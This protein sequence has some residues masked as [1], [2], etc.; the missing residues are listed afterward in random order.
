MVLSLLLAEPS[1]ALSQNGRPLP[2]SADAV[3]LLDAQGK[4]LFSK[5]A[6]EDHAP[7]SLVKLM[8]G[9]T[10]LSVEPTATA[11]STALPPSKS[12]RIPAIEASGC[13]DATAPRVPMT[14]G[15]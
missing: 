8:N 10:M 4:V 9:S 14:T 11:A 12:T 5:N 6:G 2:L 15:R 13:A 7:A 1:W 3:L